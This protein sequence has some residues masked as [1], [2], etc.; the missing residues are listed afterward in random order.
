ME[1]IFLTG[2]KPCSL[3][4]PRV[5]LPGFEL[6]RPYSN[7][8][9]KADCLQH[10]VRAPG[11]KKRFKKAYRIEMPALFPLHV[12]FI[13]SMRSISAELRLCS[14]LSFSLRSRGLIYGL[15]S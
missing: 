3:F 15:E 14:A 10:P 5:S 4:S 8:S 7:F 12:H 6:Q 9:G 2:D 1:P 11:Q 13:N